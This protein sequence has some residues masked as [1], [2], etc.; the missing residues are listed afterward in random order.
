MG[1]SN[2]KQGTGLMIVKIDNPIVY[3]GENLVGTVHLQ[4]AERCKAQNILL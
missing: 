1:S 2:S 3:A 4:I